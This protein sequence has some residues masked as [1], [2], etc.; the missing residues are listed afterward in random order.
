M[1]HL[2]P[3]VFTRGGRPLGSFKH[4]AGVPI[5]CWIVPERGEMIEDRYRIILILLTYRSKS[6][7]MVTGEKM[8]HSGRNASV[9]RIPV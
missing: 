8:K 1:G 3:A 4:L 7:Y 2:D 5:A 9:P 6:E